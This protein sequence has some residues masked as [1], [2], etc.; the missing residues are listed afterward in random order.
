[1]MHPLVMGIV[2]LFIGILMGVLVTLIMFHNLNQPQKES[3]DP[4]FFAGSQFQGRHL[5]NDNEANLSAK[6]V[7]AVLQFL[8]QELKDSGK[9]RRYFIRK[10]DEDLREAM[11]QKML[12]A[13]I[14]RIEIRDFSLGQQS[15]EFTQI[16]LN[17]AE[18]DS[19]MSLS[20][21]EVGVHI[22]YSCG[23]WLSTAIDL[24]LDQSA[25]IT[26]KLKKLEADAKLVFRRE[27]FTHWYLAFCGEPELDVDVGTQ[28]QAR[29]FPQLASLI[30]N[31]LKKSIGRR[32][33]WPSYS[34]R[35][36]PFFDSSPI[37]KFK[38]E[39]A[40]KPFDL[41]LIHIRSLDR[42]FTM[43]RKCD[44]CVVGFLLSEKS[45]Q[46]MIEERHRSE[47]DRELVVPKGLYTSVKFQD[48][49]LVGNSITYISQ[50]LPHTIGGPLREGLIL[51]A[52][53]NQ[54][55][56]GADH[57]KHLYDKSAPNVL[58]SL[59]GGYKGKF[60]DCEDLDD[61]DSEQ[62]ARVSYLLQ[63]DHV[64]HLKTTKP[65]SYRRFMDFDECFVVEYRPALDR[66]VN[67]CLLALDASSEK[68]KLLA[69]T[70]FSIEEI[71]KDCDLTLRRECQF[72]RNLIRV[73][74]YKDEDPEL[75]KHR[76][77]DRMLANGH[78]TVRFQLLVGSGENPSSST[79][80]EPI[81]R[82]TEV[83]NEPFDTR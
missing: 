72:S 25:Q 58:L 12:G 20:N 26:V 73:L 42:L 78:L 29:N 22:R 71:V 79:M 18:S 3:G 36:R 83:K 82:D 41:I 70:S 39:V 7:N 19:T 69:F 63:G 62:L 37:I 65:I 33:V 34:I 59:Q 32:H 14:R 57:A 4:P 30:G 80:S 55:V 16:S 53:N 9:V 24:V 77:Y 52:I 23:V 43:K 61:S 49:I 31:Q 8:F 35:F 38:K 46:S 21:V 11:K 76:G 66:F 56:Q 74:Q 81:V 45:M 10:L 5:Y 44:Q 47:G 51:T 27:P 54:T 64:Q 48:V 40:S 1:M 68:S 6:A 50:V 2:C 17:T 67:I 75:A 60:V 13:I 15:P 28:L